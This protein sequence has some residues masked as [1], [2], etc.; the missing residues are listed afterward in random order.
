M[1]QFL[2]DNSDQSRCYIQGLVCG[3]NLLAGVPRIVLSVSKYVNLFYHVG[4]LFPEYFP[5]EII[6]FLKNS[7]YIEEHERLRT[8]K[9]H[10]LFQTLQ[11]Y[12]YYTWDFMGLPLSQ[13]G[14]S[15]SVRHILL[16][17]SQKVAQIWHEI[18]HEALGAY[19]HIWAQTEPKLK[20]FTSEFKTQWDPISEPVLTNMSNIAKRFWNEGCINVNFV[21]C[22]HGGSAW[23]KDI[24]LA[25]YPDMDIEKKLLAHELAHTLIPE[26]Y[27]REEL[28]KAR[29]D[30]AI[31]HTIVDMIAYFSVKKHVSRPEKRGIKPNPN[32]YAH[33]EELY[34]VFEKCYMHPES[35]RDFESILKRINLPKANQH[36]S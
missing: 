17:T 33:V 27:L 2:N 19:E 20:K 10:K 7:T 15:G 4:V 8:K 26:Y 21:D 14:D 28:R 35:Y 31:S 13:A 23:I 22:V 3:G 5:D 32:Y 34:P 29:L 6:G 36:T 9:L 1:S 18:Y 12:S 24:V 25:P 11:E 30:W 16:D